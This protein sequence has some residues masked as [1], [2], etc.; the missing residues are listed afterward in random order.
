MLGKTQHP[1][2]PSYLGGRGMRLCVRGL[3]NP[4]S[5]FRFV[6]KRKGCCEL[7]STG[8]ASVMT[9]KSTQQLPSSAQWDPATPQSSM[10]VR[11]W[12]APKLAEERLTVNGYRGKPSH[13]CW[14]MWP[15]AEYPC[16]SG[17]PTP[18]GTNSTNW[19]QW[20]TRKIKRYEMG[21]EVL[22]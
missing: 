4:A 1:S 13:F 3:S 2:F 9:L 19:I 20:V 10:D 16:S 14:R 8:R 7:P 15:L 17:Y 22:G 21:G 6:L 5:S 12:R 18:T 11:T